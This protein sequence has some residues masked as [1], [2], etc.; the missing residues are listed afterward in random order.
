MSNTITN[1]ILESF[2]VFFC[3]F[4]VTRV[5]CDNIQGRIQESALGG[6][7]PS[8][9]PLPS[10]LLLLSSLLSPLFPSPYPPF[11]SPPFPSLPSPPIL[12][13]SLPSPPLRSRPPILWLWGLGE[14]SSSPSGSGRSP[15]AKR[16]LVNCKLKI[17]PVVAMVTKYTS[18]WSIAKKRNTLSCTLTTTYHLLCNG[19]HK[20][21]CCYGWKGDVRRRMKDTKS[22]TSVVLRRDFFRL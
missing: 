14:R 2:L 8:L 16:V 12:F 18:T 19:T 13:P 9:F 15:A 6:L 17:A 21:Q 7:S 5:T 1:I 4:S 20:L 3:Y 11:L 22:N 10:P